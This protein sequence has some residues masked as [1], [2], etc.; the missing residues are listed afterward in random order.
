MREWC[1]ESFVLTNVVMVMVGC[2]KSKRS[3]CT[4][5]KFLGVY[6]YIASDQN[7]RRDDNQLCPFLYVMLCTAVHPEHMPSELMYLSVNI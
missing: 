7:A 5:I 3:M 6:D 4:I 1:G 2:I